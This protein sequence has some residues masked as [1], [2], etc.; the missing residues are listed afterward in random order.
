MAGRG[1]RRQPPLASMIINHMGKREKKREKRER[2]HGLNSEP[3]SS[4]I[5]NWSYC[6]GYLSLCPL[7]L[8]IYLSLFHPRCQ[9]SH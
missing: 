1:G 8:Y 2:C 4:L 6:P 9:K 5:T 7:S 3:E